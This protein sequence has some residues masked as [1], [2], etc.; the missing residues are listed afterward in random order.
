MT[1]SIRASLRPRP[2]ADLIRRS[3]IALS[4]LAR[5]A[6]RVGLLLGLALAVAG[7]PAA[8]GDDETQA[9]GAEGTVLDSLALA[10]AHWVVLEATGAAAWRAEG[11]SEWRRFA[12]GEVLPPGCEI[13]TGPD[14]EVVLVAGG[15]Q[16]TVAPLGRLI[17]P[18]AAPGQDRRLRHE[19]GRILVHIESGRDRDVRVNTPLLSLGIKGTTFE[20]EVD[21]EQNSVVVH[22]GEV[23]VT[24][25][26]G[27][28]PVELGAGQG[29]RQPTAP[30]SPATRF[31]GAPLE[32]PASAIAAPSSVPDRAGDGEGAAAG[33]R[34]DA[35]PGLGMETDEREGPP[36]D[37]GAATDRG[38]LDRSHSSSSP[39]ER[40]WGWI[41]DWASSWA[42]VAI[43]GVA[44]LFLAIPVLVLVQIL[45]E[46]WR[47]RPG[48]QGRR[49]RELVRG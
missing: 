23:V 11:E 32:A 48:A 24:P 44:L 37:I 39:T 33:E 22:D 19:R 34:A 6:R 46:R 1:S 38:S 42:W 3:A 29:L 49:R 17:V 10:A 25:P 16:L 45:R 27:Q 18:P 4:G 20:I 15:D 40:P 9:H 41:D 47:A 35:R 5:C 8:Q 36:S 14:G 28:A 2:H 13:E 26:D 21:P 30:G 31:T 12:P 7:P 43:A